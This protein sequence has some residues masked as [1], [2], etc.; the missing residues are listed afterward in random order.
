MQ[1]ILPFFIVLLVGIVSSALVRKLHVPWV[2]A[3]IIGGIA[4]GPFGANLLEQSETLSFFSELGLIFGLSDN[5]DQ[6]KSRFL[7]L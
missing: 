6:T 5:G 3:L 2:I 4:I 7:F 1:S